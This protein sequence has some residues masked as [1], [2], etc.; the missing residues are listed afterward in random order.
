MRNEWQAAALTVGG[1]GV[2]L[3]EGLVLGDVGVEEAQRVLG[4]VL[5][6]HH[7]VGADDV[8]QGDGRQLL[9][10]VR[11]HRMVHWLVW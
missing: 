11:L 3:P 10:G 7:L 6:R 1:F 2:V 9:L 5:R 8:G 4:N